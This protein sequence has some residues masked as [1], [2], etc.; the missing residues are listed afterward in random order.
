MHRHWTVVLLAMILL[1][2]AAARAQDDAVLKLQEQFA[3][4]YG[5]ESN[6]QTRLGGLVSVISLS[7]Y[8]GEP[9]ADKLLDAAQSEDVLVAAAAWDALA[10]RAAS[11][12]QEQA[13]QWRQAGFNLAAGRSGG[14]AFPG[15]TLRRP[16]LALAAG[17]ADAV[18]TQDRSLGRL[19]QRA[20]E[21]NDPT[22][23]DGRLALEAVGQFLAVHGD[24]AMLRPLVRFAQQPGP[25]GDRAYVAL[26]QLP[27]APARDA[28]RGDWESWSRDFQAT[29]E[30]REYDGGSLFFDAPIVIDDASDDR[31]N[32]EVELG[33]LDIRGV[34]VAL[35]IDATGSLETSNPYI[36]G[37]L[38][39][40]AQ[41]LS[42]LSN[43]VRFGVCYYRHEVRPDLQTA[44]CREEAE[45]A[46]R[47]EPK[48][49]LV[50]FVPM[51]GNS[52]QLFAAMN[53]DRIPSR[54]GG[55]EGNG[56]MAAGLE[57]AYDLLNRQ[58]RPGAAKVIVL[59]GDTNPTPGTTDALMTMAG[60][61]KEAKVIVPLLIRDN[62][63]ARRLDPIA[64]AATGNDAISYRDDLEAIKD[65]G[66]LP[67]PYE[68]FPDR[69]FGQIATLIVTASLPS[70]YADRGPQVVDL[71]ATQL[72]AAND[73]GRAAVR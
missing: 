19:L 50:D 63:T 55:H 14:D 71:V 45:M 38:G 52:N 17:Q 42:V 54:G 18:P 9:L 58:G 59:Q 7:R 32:Q 6:F 1:L 65:A 69:P 43:D 13:N 33:S 30:P 4:L 56:A 60:L 20:V 67:N 68:N 5:K 70:D 66:G 26:S 39:V 16:M 64:Q 53:V 3:A 51:T 36:Q 61:A 72:A 23:E 8:D 27:D 21:Q 12:T 46:Q 22:T 48:R 35:A 57:G 73:A 25:L 31:F 40:T 47:R 2:P 41:T 10:A 37:Y 29:G 15:P 24:T 11:L 34:D 49:F 62:A 28:N 44:C